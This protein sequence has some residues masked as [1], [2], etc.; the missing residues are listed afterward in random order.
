VQTYGARGT[1]TTDD[2][3][4]LNQA[5][6]AAART[7][8]IVELPA[9][10]YQ[11][12]PQ[13]HPQDPAYAVC[14]LMRGGVIL[15]GAG[16]GATTIR[17]A[18]H[19][20]LPAPSRHISL[21]LNATINPRAAQLAPDTAMGIE[22]LTL[23]GTAPTQDAL[24]HGLVWI[25]CRAVQHTRVRVRNVYGTAPSGPA[26]TVGFEF[27]LGA[28]AT[29]TE[30]EAVTTDGGPSATG[31]SADRATDL[32]YVSCLAHGQ[33]V[34]QG[35]THYGCAVLR[36]LNC[37]AHSNGGYGFNSEV[38]EDVRYATCV[39][40]GRADGGGEG[41]YAAHQPLGNGAAGFFVRGSTVVDLLGCASRFNAG[42]GL[43]IAHQ[44]E[45]VRVVGGAYAANGGWGIAVAAEARGVAISHETALA[46]NGLGAVQAQADVNAATPFVFD[47]GWRQAG[48]APIALAHGLPDRPRWVTVYGGT[49]GVPTAEVGVP[50]YTGAVLASSTHLWAPELSH[51]Q[52][53][54]VI[55]LY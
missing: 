33:T 5:I 29:Y 22:D 17:L 1:G 18:P 13:P 8:G 23:D 2:T 35:F 55:A 44:A 15:R 41:P 4:A 7:G 25:R 16:V 45:G 54:R 31:F 9:G 37:Y 34:G 6:A 39:A 12:A 24:T 38:S 51:G 27:Q 26:E 14:V 11:V 36:Y 40:G 30:C 28:Q 21:L 32:S 49:A 20:A 43:W 10:I 48:A 46:G 50:L 3:P 42:H 19:A 47:S 52:H 53:Y